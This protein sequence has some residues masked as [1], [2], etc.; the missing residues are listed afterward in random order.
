MGS[1]IK[2]FMYVSLSH[3]DVTH[4][5]VLQPGLLAS[6]RTVDANECCVSVKA[7]KNCEV[8]Y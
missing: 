5:V 2:Y 1:S 3:D 4:H 6:E 8:R 7:A